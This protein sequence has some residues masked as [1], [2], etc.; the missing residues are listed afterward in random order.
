MSFGNGQ[1]GRFLTAAAVF[2]ALTI[3]TLNIETVAVN[4]GLDQLAVDIIGP[5]GLGIL[6]NV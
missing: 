1:F 4:F 6:R 3:I 5:R 2:V